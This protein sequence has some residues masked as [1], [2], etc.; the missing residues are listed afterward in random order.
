MSEEKKESGDIT[1]HPGWFGLGYGTRGTNSMILGIHADWPAYPC[2]PGGNHGL[3]DLAQFPAG[4]RFFPIDDIDRCVLF[5]A[6]NYDPKK[7]ER[8]K[9]P[10]SP[11]AF[12]V[13]IWHEDLMPLQEQGLISGITPISRREFEIR[14]R[15]EWEWPKRQLFIEQKDG[16]KTRVILPPLPPAPDEE[17]FWAGSYSYPAFDDDADGTEGAITITPAGW[18]VVTQQLAEQLELPDSMP[19]LKK[20]LDNELYDHAVREV[21]IAIEEEL[22]LAVGND[23]DFGQRLVDKFIKHLDS[24]LFAYNTILR[25]YRL[26]LRTFFKFTRNPHAHRKITLTSPNALALTTHALELLDDIQQFRK[27]NAVTT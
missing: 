24:E 27:K 19:D 20:L 11:D 9:D 14:R 18:K 26:R 10:L 23:D 21:S 16:S 2:A 22:R 1:E 3:F 25:I 13:A 7:P 8:A 12:Q 17:D 6:Y 4:T 15:A 5:S